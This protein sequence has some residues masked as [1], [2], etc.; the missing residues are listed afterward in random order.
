MS[1]IRDEIGSV[2]IRKQEY[3]KSTPPKKAVKIGGLQK[4]PS[5]EVG[6]P[7]AKKLV[8]F[9]T[10]AYMVSTPNDNF[11]KKPFIDLNKEPLLTDNVFQE[12]DD[13]ESLDNPGDSTRLS[14]K[15]KDR[16]V[17]RGSADF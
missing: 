3:W 8:E 12:Q 6:I 17:F 7:E 9:E 5:Q 14:K 16:Y 1:G 13:E 10:G 11:L 4:L 2:A 15:T